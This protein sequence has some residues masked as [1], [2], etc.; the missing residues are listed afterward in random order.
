MKDLGIREGLCL[1][2]ASSVQ[3]R[4]AQPGGAF[5]GMRVLDCG[6]KGPPV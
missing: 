3:Q 4:L 1:A 5:G 2:G 6:G